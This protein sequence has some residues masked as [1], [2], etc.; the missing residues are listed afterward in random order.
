MTNLTNGNNKQI[1]TI[2]NFTDMDELRISTHVAIRK[3][4]PD[5]VSLS[6]SAGSMNFTFSMTV[7]SAR[8]LAQMLINAARE[9]EV[10]A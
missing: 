1:R 5:V 10:G 7:P 6:Q 8:A 3:S 4:I 9:F 2:K